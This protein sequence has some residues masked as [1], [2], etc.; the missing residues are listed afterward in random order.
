MAGKVS[1]ELTWGPTCISSRCRQLSPLSAQPPP[2][3]L[4]PS[5]LHAVEAE[6][7]QP[8][9]GAHGAPGCGQTTPGAPVNSQGPGSSPPT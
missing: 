9:H 5:H 7:P 4:L 3:R 1:R 8:C 6:H 2:P